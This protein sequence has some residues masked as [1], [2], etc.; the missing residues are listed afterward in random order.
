MVG[1]IDLRKG[2][3]QALAAFEA[4][5]AEG[6]DVKL[7]IVGQP[8]WNVETLVKRLMNHPESGR[9][10][11]WFGRA[12]DM[13]LAALYKS[14]T[15]L[16]A[17]SEAEGFGLPLVEAAQ[18]G[19]PIIARDVPVFREI[20]GDNVF[21]FSGLTAEALADA[22][23]D[24]LRLE[25]NGLAPRPDGLQWSPGSRA[26]PIFCGSFWMKTRRIGLRMAYHVTGEAGAQ[27]TSRWG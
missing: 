21:Y 24:W 8:S 2:Y 25:E 15:V 23:K 27:K 20:A 26:P 18:R 17:A 16:L 13:F 6:F 3:A 1:T 7:V 19:L 22:L 14:C 9:R 11:F 10:L 4:L 5:W 12:D